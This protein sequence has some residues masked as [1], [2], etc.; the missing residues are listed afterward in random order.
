MQKPKL[1]DEF[2]L[3]KELE[4]IDSFEKLKRLARILPQYPGIIFG[5]SVRTKEDGTQLEKIL[6]KLKLSAQEVP[7]KTLITEWWQLI[8]LEAINP[9]FLLYL[10]EL[11]DLQT[12]PLKDEKNTPLYASLL[13]LSQFSD[14]AIAYRIWLKSVN[15][16]GSLRAGRNFDSLDHLFSNG[17]FFAKLSLSHLASAEP[18]QVDAF[19]RPLINEKCT[20]KEFLA[21]DCALTRILKLPDWAD[22][23]NVI[24]IRINILPSLRKLNFTEKLLHDI[25]N[26]WK[27]FSDVIEF[28]KSCGDFS[29]LLLRDEIV[30]HIET[31]ANVVQ[32]VA[33]LDIPQSVYSLFTTLGAPFNENVMAT[34]NKALKEQLKSMFV[35]FTYNNRQR[36]ECALYMPQ[37]NE[38]MQ[39][40]GDSSY[41]TVLRG[42]LQ[43]GQAAGIGDAFNLLKIIDS[44]LQKPQEYFDPGVFAMLPELCSDL[45]EYLTQQ[46]IQ[47]SESGVKSS[48]ADVLAELKYRL[49]HMVKVNKLASE[50]FELLMGSLRARLSLFHHCTIFGLQEGLFA[51]NNE[52]KIDVDLRARIQEIKIL[53]LCEGDI[54]EPRT[55]DS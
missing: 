42:R 2:N 46:V 52:S 12:I 1:A 3:P 33:V 51:G 30:S 43:R 32:L 50:H 8:E 38:E 13:A 7:Y 47:Y 41:V 39:G 36:L 6:S 27:N 22:G 37:K 48:K 17:N 55:L 26:K 35:S 10:I 28:V 14:P 24:D 11:C 9:N 21:V 4:V 18:E 16:S 19:L 25:S 49:I 34:R 44:A 45:F 15:L 54:S 29:V 5:R 23:S 20:V 40:H 53:A 31:Y